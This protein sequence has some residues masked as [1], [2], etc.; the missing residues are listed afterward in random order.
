VTLYER[1]ALV[2]PPDP[3]APPAPKAM[4]VEEAAQALARLSRH[5]RYADE[6]GWKQLI[7]APELIGHAYR[8]A[9][10]QGWSSSDLAL[11]QRARGVLLR[12]AGS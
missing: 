8:A 2:V 5:V 11:A 7:G 12:H 10:G 4:T 1:E 6:G 3:A 9:V